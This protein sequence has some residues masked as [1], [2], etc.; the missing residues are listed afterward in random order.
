MVHG[1]KY[2]LSIDTLY[3][4]TWLYSLTL[5]CAVVF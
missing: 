4:V 5:H 3:N 1:I 2:F